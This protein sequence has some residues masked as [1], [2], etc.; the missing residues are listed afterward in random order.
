M[1][2]TKKISQLE[3]MIAMIDNDD[4]GCRM[5]PL[6]N[7]VKAEIKGS[8]GYITIGVPAEDVYNWLYNKTGHGGLFLIDKDAFAAAKKTLEASA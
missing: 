5:A 7:V 8:N 3:V 1:S 4:P 6:N 2:E